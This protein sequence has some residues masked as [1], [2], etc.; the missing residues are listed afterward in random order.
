MAEILLQKKP[1]FKRKWVKITTI[2]I[3]VV[4]FLLM[5]TAAFGYWFVTKSLPDLE[6]EMV[7]KHVQGE[8]TVIRDDRGVAQINAANIKDMFFV[9]GYITGQDRLFQMDM[10]RRLASGQLSEV[11]GEAAL[12]TDIFYRS[13]GMHRTIDALMEKVDPETEEIVN[14]YANGVNAYIEEAFSNGKQ[15]LEFR[16]LG[17][18]PE[19]WS[20]RDT[21]LVVKY[22]GY[23]LS[24][25][26]RNELTNYQLIKELGP[27]A[28]K[29]YL[30]E[31]QVDD[32]FPTIYQTDEIEPFSAQSLLKLA[33]HAPS[34]FNGSNNWVISGEHTES[35][36]PMIANDPH[37]ALDIPG[38][39]YQTHLNL[40]GDFH[41]IGVTV[42]G[43]PGVTLG[44]NEH[45]AWGVT[46]LS[47]D[48]EDLF[49][50]RVHPEKP[51]YY[52]FD[53]S[54]E[55]ADVF[56]E[57]I[58]IKDAEEPH[59]ERVEVTRNGPIINKV[60]NGNAPYQAIAFNWTGFQAGEEI[61]NFLNLTRATNIIEFNKALDG[62][63][64]PA[65]SWVFADKQ[66]NIGYRGQA[67]MP[68]RQSSG[69]LPVP[70]WDPQYQWDGFIPNSEV[71]RIVNP[72]RGYIVTANNKPVDDSYPYEIG[73]SF[74]PYRAE[75]ITE[76][77]ETKI[78]K[79]E[80]FKLED[81]QAIQNDFLNSQSRALI[82]LLVK[83]LERSF[84][85]IE[86]A[87]EQEEE[88]LQLL[89]DWDFVE[90]SDSAAAL[91]WN[92]W[93]LTFNEALFKDIVSFNYSHRAVTHR[94]LLEA[95]QHPEHLLF[96]DLEK[97]KQKSLD[98]LARDTFIE[99]IKNIEEL[100]GDNPAKWEWGNWHRMTLEHPLGSVKPLHL[101]F[102]VG[103]WK[104]GGS[105]ATPGAISFDSTTGSANHGAGWRFIGDLS[106]DDNYFD[107]IMPGQSG[108]VFSPFYKDQAD[109]WINQELFPMIYNK[110][111]SK[112]KKVYIFKPGN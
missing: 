101:L 39:W 50:E 112:D 100:Q 37:L 66:G 53:G 98:S 13:I 81:M 9:Q 4:L 23:M 32:A 36:F 46:A 1:V 11:V 28:A 87:T 88:V 15:P 26:H 78:S 30:S 82:P 2:I 64:T 35:G 75:R 93:Y 76:M 57:K 62:F 83:A 70:G 56:E 63:V 24:G 104:V 25:D 67:L 58:N 54:W 60:L 84:E 96:T 59:I 20:I 43:V 29:A 95:D 90:T 55:Q 109:E 16:L 33:A 6:G 47:V 19:P 18:K 108:Q 3:S 5:L 14:A 8:V 12:E 71:P 22:M 52:E 92:H 102:N 38:I 7:T 74:Y 106:S 111:E 51:S 105:G 21:G 77:I 103:D 85:S 34:E 80:L 41:S 91:I 42:P 107:I 40:E 31:Y 27:E 99:A 49:L 94:M 68:V 69:Q 48:Q 61:N 79:N 72:D 17:Y 97:D 110:E 10:T 44:H 65:L 45:M 86:Q 73:R 89:K